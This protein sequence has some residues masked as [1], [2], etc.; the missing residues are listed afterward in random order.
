M[1]VVRLQ[2]I[3]YGD[4]KRAVVGYYDLARDARREIQRA[5]SEQGDVEVGRVW[6]ERL[7]EC[8]IC[9]GNVLIEMGDLG[10][11]RRHF[12]G[13]RRGER[14]E[15]LDGRLAMVCLRMG[16][17]QAA[18]GYLDTGTEGGDDDRGEGTK[19]VIRPLLSMAD[20]RY[21][22][23]VEEWRALRGG[24]WDTIAT[25]NLAVCL[26]YAG[27]LH[28]VSSTMTFSPTPLKPSSSLSNS[29]SRPLSSLN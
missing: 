20:D 19:D 24:K 4:L 2:A 8:G 28:E 26:L 29:T 27:K 6:R 22:D 23:A 9:V 15:V 13:L 10:T 5:R 21:E 3:A 17:V 1:L 12:E 16:D 11:A 14:D 25:Q 18:R 7:T